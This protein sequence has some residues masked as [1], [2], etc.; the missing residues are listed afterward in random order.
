MKQF[1]KLLLLPMVCLLTSCVDDMKKADFEKTIQQHAT[2]TINN[3][4]YAGSANGF[5]YFIH[6]TA[7]QSRK[8]RVSTAEIALASHFPLTEDKQKWQLVKGDTDP[9][10]QGNPIEHIDDK[11]GFKIDSG[12]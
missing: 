9:F 12:K 3:V 1:V 4:W 2:E 7:T 8:I 5:D 6:N 11:S 10:L